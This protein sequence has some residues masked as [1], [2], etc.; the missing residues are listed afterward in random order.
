M[1]LTAAL[2]FWSNCEHISSLGLSFI[3]VKCGRGGWGVILECRVHFLC[4]DANITFR[5]RLWLNNIFEI[6]YYISFGTSLLSPLEQ[7]VRFELSTSGKGS[8]SVG[9][10]SPELYSKTWSPQGTKSILGM[11]KIFRRS[12]RKRTGFPP[13]LEQGFWGWRVIRGTSWAS[14]RVSQPGAWMQQEEWL[15]DACIPVHQGPWSCGQF[16]ILASPDRIFSHLSYLWASTSSPFFTLNSL[17]GPFW[18]DSSLA[19]PSTSMST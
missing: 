14:K 18:S 16:L 15:C 2:Y 4:R 17:H 6:N 19:S 13:W 10:S 5:R 1:F 11:A 3:M 12:R 8:D 9:K 7:M